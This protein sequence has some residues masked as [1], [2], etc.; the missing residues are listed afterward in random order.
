MK[1]DDNI[2]ELLIKYN[3]NVNIAPDGQ[4]LLEISLYWAQRK[5]HIKI[6]QLLSSASNI[7]INEK[8]CN[9][10]ETALFD[11]CEE[12]SLECVKCLLSNDSIC[13]NKTGN[14][15]W[16]PLYIASCSGH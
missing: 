10:G 8:L 16:T 11:A 3:A 4:S 1:G 9:R 2:V 12:G 7:K 5:G 13:I 6:L 15:G 14:R